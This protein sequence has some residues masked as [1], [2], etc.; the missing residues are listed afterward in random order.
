[1]VVCRGRELRPFFFFGGKNM[2]KTTKYL[3][4]AAVIAALYAVLTHLQ[5]LLRPGAATCGIQMRL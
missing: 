5:N 2:R 1:M 3:A 4:Q